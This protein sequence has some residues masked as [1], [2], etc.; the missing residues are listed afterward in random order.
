M[1]RIFA[2]AAAALVS[3][4]AFAQNGGLDSLM[5]QTLRQGYTS[6]PADKAVRNALNAVA[7]N[8]IAVNAENAAMI[9]TEFTEL[10]QYAV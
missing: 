1:K 5:L 9:D 3:L 2:L 7:L 8:T 10:M 4:G 6:S